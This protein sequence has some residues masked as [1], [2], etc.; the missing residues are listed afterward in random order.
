MQVTNKSFYEEEEGNLFSQVLFK[1][2]PYW[3]LFLVLLVLS[4]SAAYVYLHYAVP[5]Y[6]TAATVMVKDEKKGLD[7]S[8]LMEQLNLFGSKKLVENEIEVIQ[9]RTLMREVV[10][11]LDLYAPITQEGRIK[12]RSA[13]LTSPVVIQVR[14]PDSLVERHKV[15]FTFDSANREVVVAGQKYPLGS[16][17]STPYGN[18]R[19]LT[20]PNYVAADKTRPLYFSLINV[21]AISD[22]LL[23]GLKV[24]QATKLSSVID[25]KIKDAIP[26][27]GEDILNGL[28]GEYNKA[29][30]N[31]KNALAA[32]TLRFINERLGL[33]SNELD[34]VE[35]GI[36]KYKTQEGIVDIS[37]QGQLYL[38]NVGA[39]DQKLSE[40]NVQLAVLDQVERYVQSKSNEAG[41][42]PSTFGVDDPVLGQLLQKLYDLEI[43]YEG[44]S[45]TTAENNPVLISIRHEM[46]KIK[47]SIME[48]VQ[49]LR[50]NL[51]AG[52]GNL[53]NTSNSY[54]SIL[55]TLPAKERKL[56]EISRQQG[57]KNSI[58]SF[59]L[60]KREET[61]LTFSSAIAD[62]RII[63]AAA[64][65]V[66]PVAPKPILIWALAVLAALGLGAGII[67]IREGLNQRIVFRSEIE[68]F[69][70]VPVVGEIMYAPA[71]DELVVT[72]GKRSVIAEQFKQL[73]TSLAYI[74]I[75]S[76]KKK[77]L[78]TSTISGEGK[79]FVTANLAVSLALTDK[80]V[81]LL[82]LDL[83]KP[84]VAHLF[85]VSREVG[86]TNYFI[87]N[88]DADHIIK[89]TD[90]SPNL[91][92]IPSGAIPPNPSE[93][94]LNGKL[95][96]LLQYLETI[97]DYILIDTA[98]T[99]PVTDA[100]ILS[101]LCDATIYVVRH[102]V[103]PK[104]Y[105]KMLDEN[106]K[107]RGLKNLAIVFNG[108]KNRGV[109]GINYGY[110]YGYGKEYGYGYGEEK[111]SKKKDKVSK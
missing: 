76:R 96:E 74:G 14:N 32:N 50:R 69:T 102:K 16:W 73:R 10:K 100:Y 6:E 58:Y 55:R 110:G 52:R 41:I 23:A 63:D 90:V 45:K 86:L 106:M 66:M 104:G 17:V 79:S 65:T 67:A 51:T 28:I 99:A 81:V 80:K 12:S 94:I 47:P 26:K 33:I 97:F 85:N 57:I 38:N 98:P 53:L 92:V 37:A 8:N 35:H 111:K 88:K 89:R 34:S 93:L 49:S 83:R 82:E 48:N 30:I 77:I 15:Y 75:N 103:T 64:T 18:L 1:Y 42:V 84:N 107:V 56:V 95:D 54:A 19:F 4:G 40:M 13:Y 31:D 11:N 59:L 9:S 72:Q 62:T 109:G 21:R 29:G 44:L 78:V 7:D 27:R 5:V 71:H 39:N 101:P 61:A 105:I 60:Q 25:L 87:G 22:E 3:P 36:Q 20:N 108:V 43:K 68:K 2:L 24:T 70:T 46:E 91:F